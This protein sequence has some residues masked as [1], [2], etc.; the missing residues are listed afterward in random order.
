MYFRPRRPNY[1]RTQ[2]RHWCF[3]INN[4]TE[5]AIEVVA[6]LKKHKHFRYCILQKEHGEA[7]TPHYQGYIEFRDKVRFNGVRALFTR[8]PHIEKRRGTRDEARAYCTKLDGRLEEP[9]ESGE[10]IG[11]NGHR[12]DIAAAAALVVKHGNLVSLI[13]T[14]PGLYVKYSRGFESL[15]Y[16]SQPD[17]TDPPR[18]IL[19]Y[20]PTGTGK[21]RYAYERFPE[22]YRKQPG[23]TWFDGYEAADVL[24]LDDFAGKMSKMEL[25]YVLILLDR[26]PVQ[27]AVKGSFRKVTATTILIT[28]NIHPRCWYDYTRREEH[29]KAL[30][31]RIHEVWWFKAENEH[32]YIDK[33]SFFDD[34]WEGCNE[35]NVFNNITRPNT[36][37]VSDEDDI[38]D[39]TSD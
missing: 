5:T 35:D 8:P 34:W 2:A 25:Q 31:R 28:T 20:G 9:V 27:V 30:A 37:V 24:L 29:Y 13:E 32:L 18:V 38:V 7:G 17:R 33:R 22:C 36:P 4:P 6:N 19:L 10:W 21:T 23:D 3:T 39:L 16:R 15:A 14:F 11:G 26:Y 1:G 12:S